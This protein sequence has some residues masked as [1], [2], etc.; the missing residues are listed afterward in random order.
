MLSS[1]SLKHLESQEF[2]TSR[3]RWCGNFSISSKLEDD[4]GML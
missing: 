2:D 3:T 4:D 1:S